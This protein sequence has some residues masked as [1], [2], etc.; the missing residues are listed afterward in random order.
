MVE[1]GIG[2]YNSLQNKKRTLLQYRYY[3][4]YLTLHI[5]NIKELTI[6]I[7]YKI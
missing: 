5:Y 1:L 2:K 7:H 4:I 3:N 6:L